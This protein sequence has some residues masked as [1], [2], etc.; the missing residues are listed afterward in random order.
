M[1]KEVV[2]EA[3]KTLPDNFQLDALVE[4]LI[5]IEQVEAGLKQIDEGQGLP[6][7]KAR[8]IVAGWQK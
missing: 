2:T 5:F 8:N 6:L 4:R 7:D 3:L 1:N